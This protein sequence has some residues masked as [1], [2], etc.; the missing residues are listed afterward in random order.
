[1]KRIC[2][3]CFYRTD[4]ILNYFRLYHRNINHII[5]INFDNCFMDTSRRIGYSRFGINI[6]INKK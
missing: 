5:K 6:K 4:N 1:M 3:L 2:I